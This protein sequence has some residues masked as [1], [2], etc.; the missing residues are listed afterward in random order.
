LHPGISEVDK[1]IEATR[2]YIWD[3]VSSSE[4]GISCAEP[5]LEG[6]G[7]SSEKPRTTVCIT[8]SMWDDVGEVLCQPIVAGEHFIMM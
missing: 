4:I 1:V 6:S 7:Y 5:I 3:Q 8:F 2:L